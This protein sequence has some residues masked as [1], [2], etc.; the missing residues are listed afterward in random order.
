M[1]D[2]N[3][4]REEQSPYLLQHADNPVHWYPWGENAFAKAKA[5][6]KPV[7]LSIGYA[8]C[9]W[10]HVMAHESFEDPEVAEQLN[11]SFVSIKVDRE[12][13]PDIDH[14]Y[15]MVCQMMTGGGGWPL[16]V[17]MTPDR[18]PFYAATYI[19]KEGRFGRPGLMQLL[20]RIEKL[21][22]E[23]RKKLL[24][25]ADKVT[26]ALQKAEQLTGDEAPTPELIR[27]A[28][29]TLR[30]QYD[31][32]YG[33]FGRAPKF[34]S[35]HNLTFLLR[36]WKSTGEDQWLD[37][38][39]HTLTAMR[40]GG[41]F[42]H[43]GFGFHRYSTDRHWLLPHFEKM[44]YDQAML[45]S[46]YSEAWQITGNRL[47]RK[48]ADQIIN[49]TTRVLQDEGGAFY[50]AEDADSEGVEGKF[51]LWTIDEVRNVLEPA[52][53][54]LFIEVYNLDETGNFREESSGQTTGSNIPH[55]QQSV[56]ALA[57]EREM[58]P[59]QLESHL[60]NARQKLFQEREKRVRP[61][62]DDK[63]LTDWNGLM[64]AALAKAGRMFGKDEYTESAC[65][66]AEFIFDEM[67]AE[68]HRLLHRYRK[69]E[70]A[71]AGH[72]DDYAFMIYGLLELHQ[73][74][75]ETKWL[76]EAIA[77]QKAFDKAFWDEEDGGYFFTG[78]G[79]E[80][81]ITRQK[82]LYDGAAPSANSIALDNLLRLSQLTG[83]ARLEQ[84]AD[85]LSRTFTSML[86]ES[87]QGYTQFLQA[88]Q[89]IFDQPREMV[90]AGSPADSVFQEM[91]DTVREIYLP[92]TILLSNPEQPDQ[93]LQKLAPFLEHQTALQG[94]TTAYVC[95]NRHC[96]QPVFSVEDLKKA[97]SARQG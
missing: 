65:R 32:E 49:Y 10:C 8:T 29:G 13:R 22:Q 14:V 86:K 7:F 4:L 55:L 76:E 78:S 70:A 15:M 19:P 36:Q 26:Q 75:L 80:V 44:L 62:L 39:T 43:V 96:E 67:T 91:L 89:R 23:D 1:P 85:R 28:T 38:V 93:Q 68:N 52:E 31:A 21:W 83:D 94:K 18:K 88:L 82:Q 63:I 2:H 33:G 58:I 64:I 59:S 12:E 27:E 5:E 81:L 77:F 92:F 48:T 95:H 9:H 61:M 97:L 45:L 17:V 56:K 60:E 35:P 3:H 42:D 25:S 41:L 50:S 20:P 71:I 87:P 72:A 47:F 24:Q 6:D 34:P 57:E 16:T 66:A 30:K 54:E 53:A 46:A 37:M 84:Q 40:Q 73:A 74:T 11:H 69:G 90:I 79:A 51:Y